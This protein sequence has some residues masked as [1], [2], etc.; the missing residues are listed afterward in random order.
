ML[1]G[2]IA[3]PLVQNLGVRSA[4][5]GLSARAA[6]G[7]NHANNRARN[8]VEAVALE[9]AKARRRESTGKI[10][11]ALGQQVLLNLHQSG[12]LS[13]VKRFLSD[14]PRGTLHS[15]WSILYWITDSELGFHACLPF[16]APRRWDW[17]RRVSRVRARSDKNGSDDQKSQ[18]H[19]YSP[20]YED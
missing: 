17:S 10:A 4:E 8:D 14:A 6:L 9:R 2:F 5:V 15:S 1:Q 12:D 3:G 7:N 20:G 19:G 18:A 16:C 11:E 13:P